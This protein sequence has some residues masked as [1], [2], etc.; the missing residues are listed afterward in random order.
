MVYGIWNIQMSSIPK[1]CVV[2]WESHYFFFQRIGKYAYNIQSFQLKQNWNVASASSPFI[3]LSV[4]VDTV[5][6]IRHKDR[7]F[8]SM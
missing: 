1:S 3:T 7:S 8:K 2:T 6:V 5:P 4:D